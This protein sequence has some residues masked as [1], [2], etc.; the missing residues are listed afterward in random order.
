MRILK[1]KQRNHRH[2]KKLRRWEPENKIKNMRKKR[3]LIKKENKK[4]KNFGLA[5][6]LPKSKGL[7]I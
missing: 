5:K 2:R 1:P 6:E 3:K 4:G 7:S